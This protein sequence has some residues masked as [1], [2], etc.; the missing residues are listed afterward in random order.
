M[1]YRAHGVWRMDTLRAARLPARPARRYDDCIA[2]LIDND[3]QAIPAPG[4]GPAARLRF[5]PPGMPLRPMDSADWNRRHAGEEAAGASDAS[6]LL[7]GEVAGLAPGSAIDLACG[8]G[9][10]AI[11]LAQQGWQ[12][13]AVDFAKAGLDKARQLARSRR[14]DARI[15]FVQADLRHHATGE[16]QYAL[17]LLAYLHLPQQ[18]LTPILARAARAVAPGG[19]FLLLAHD[20]DSFALSYGGPQHPELLYRLDRVLALLGPSFHIDKAGRTGG[21][22]TASLLVRAT[23]KP[24]ATAHC[25]RAAA[26]GSAN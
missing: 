24:D 10:H 9:R 23:R 22:A 26:P 21:G 13:R 14:V 3:M 4:A 25:A 20:A 17:V 18:E 6:P 16:R 15:D 19:T 11:W 7:A 12:V 2:T 5:P 1:I 8:A